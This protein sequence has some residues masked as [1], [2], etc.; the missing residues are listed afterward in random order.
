M[1]ENKIKVLLIDD[2]P[3]VLNILKRI[4]D[5][6]PE[7]LVIGTAK[8]G[9]EGLE[10]VRFLNPDVICTDLMM[11]VMD[12]LEFTKQLMETS[13][14]P[15]LVISAALQGEN[16]TNVFQ[17]LEA[18]ALDIFPKPAGG[19]DKDYDL[20]RDRLVS[21]IR[22]IKSIPVYKKAKKNPTIE[23]A[24]YPALPS[25]SSKQIIKFLAIGASTGG[26]NA[27]QQILGHLPKEISVPVL[28]VQHISDGFIDSMVGWLGQNTKLKVKIMQEGE[29][30]V[31]GTVYFPQNLKHM[32]IGSDGK[33]HVSNDPPFNGHSPSVNVLF[34]SLAMYAGDKTLAVI[35]TGMGDDGATGLLTIKHTGGKT[36]GEAESTCVVYGMPKVAKEIGALDIQLPIDKIASHILGLL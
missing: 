17:L 22:V 20:I 15:I 24:S 8:N 7:V 5:K 6:S 29:T 34:K 9:S 1:I 10:Q 33:L 27:V 28:C 18:G 13:P 2:S 31:A 4:L 25:H 30:P 3:I 21:K 12:G 35:L 23:T 32:V 36:I 26:P 19:T 14:K 16:E 11:P